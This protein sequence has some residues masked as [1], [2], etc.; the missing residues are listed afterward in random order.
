MLPQWPCNYF[1]HCLSC[2]TWRILTEILPDEVYWR[3]TDDLLEKMTKYCTDL[4]TAAGKAQRYHSNPVIN[5]YTACHDPHDSTRKF[6]RETIFWL[7]TK[8]LLDKTMMKY[9]TDRQIQW[10]QLVATAPT[11][12]LIDTLPAVP[13]MTIRSRNS[14]GRHFFDDGWT[15]GWMKQQRNTTQIQAETAHHYCTDPKIKLFTACHAPYNESTQNATGR[16]LLTTDVG[17][18]TGRNN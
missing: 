9:C 12:K 16:N 17:R 7:W 2:P 1:I 11:Q 8:D 4:E 6:N 5:L 13:H 18:P 14:T 10:K 3:P 15:T